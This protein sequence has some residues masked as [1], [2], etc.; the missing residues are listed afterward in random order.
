MIA[1]FSSGPVSWQSPK[2]YV[3]ASESAAPNSC[4]SFPA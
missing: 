3:L 2:E 1:W 4:V